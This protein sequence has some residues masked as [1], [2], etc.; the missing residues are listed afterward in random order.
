ME[1]EV[2]NAEEYLGRVRRIR[3]TR[4]EIFRQNITNIVNKHLKCARNV[5]TVNFNKEEHPFLSFEE[6]Q[7]C[8]EFFSND[9]VD[10]QGYNSA[11]MKIKLSNNPAIWVLSVD[12]QVFEDPDYNRKRRRTRSRSRSPHFNGPVFSPITQTDEPYDPFKAYNPNAGYDE[13]VP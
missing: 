4:N 6:A 9:L 11:S 5:F 10:K 1:T 2:I 8:L 3:S 7:N 12:I 13:Y